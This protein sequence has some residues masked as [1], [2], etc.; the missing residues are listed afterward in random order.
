M[1]LIPLTKGQFAMVDDEDHEWISK[2]NWFAKETNP[3]GGFVAKRTVWVHDIYSRKSKSVLISMAA[4]ILGRDVTGHKIHPDHK[5]RNPL[6][7]RR[8]NLRWASPMQNS[9]NRVRLNNQN[10][11]GVNVRDGK[12]RARICV[13][14][15]LMTIGTFNSF[16]EA[17][18]AYDSEAKKYFGEF[19][20]A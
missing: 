6:N 11:R 4:S 13:N 10:T 3:K 14:Y 20:P 1:K 5:D 9:A 15:K 19:F 17:K 2:L 8:A 7:N 12:F 16:A 18:A